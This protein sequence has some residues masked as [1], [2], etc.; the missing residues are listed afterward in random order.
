EERRPR[1]DRSRRRTRSGR[2]LAAE[3]NG[4]GPGDQFAA[5]SQTG[6]SHS[7]RPAAED[8]DGGTDAPRRRRR[9][10]GGRSR[11]GGGGAVAQQPE[12]AAGPE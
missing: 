8:G 11:T 6:E 9:R 4:G 3:G 1:R 12:G 7:A 10:R 5:E 2:P